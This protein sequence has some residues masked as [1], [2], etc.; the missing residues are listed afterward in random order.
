MKLYE[1]QILVLN[2][3]NKNICII[4]ILD[5]A[6]RRLWLPSQH[7]RWVLVTAPSAGRSHKQPQHSGESWLQM[8]VSETFSFRTFTDMVAGVQ[9]SER[10]G[11]TTGLYFVI[12]HRFDNLA[13]MIKRNY[14]YQFN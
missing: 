7:H 11:E 2:Y 12:C 4:W 14:L 5:P 13:D 9:G 3:P 10:S 8:L 1:K 6:N